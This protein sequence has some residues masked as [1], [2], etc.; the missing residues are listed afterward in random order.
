[1]GHG[2]TSKKVNAKDNRTA[3]D[4]K[5][6]GSPSPV[7]ERRQFVEVHSRLTHR[8]LRK[9]THANGSQVSLGRCLWQSGRVSPD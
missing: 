9:V 3:A 1:M 8:F 6:S 7:P 2:R 5:V 4:C